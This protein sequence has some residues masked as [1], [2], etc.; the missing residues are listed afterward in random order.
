VALSQPP[1]NPSNPLFFKNLYPF[2]VSFRSIF[3]RENATRDAPKNHLWMCLE[4]SRRHRH[5]VQFLQFLPDAKKLHG[6][7]TADTL[8]VPIVGV[9]FAERFEIPHTPAS[10]EKNARADKRAGFYVALSVPSLG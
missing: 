6:D 9:S 1:L 3:A 7:S 5:L 4:Q 8:L 10:A 2:G